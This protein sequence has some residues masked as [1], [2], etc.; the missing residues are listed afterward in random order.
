[1]SFTFTESFPKPATRETEVQL[2]MIR[3]IVE[4]RLADEIL[5]RMGTTSKKQET[6]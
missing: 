1:M 2:R 3:Q 6:A 5:H 4:A